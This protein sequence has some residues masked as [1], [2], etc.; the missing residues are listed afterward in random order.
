MDLTTNP[1]ASVVT[2]ADSVAKL[3]ADLDRLRDRIDRYEFEAMVAR[4]MDGFKGQHG[5]AQLELV[6]HAKRTKRGRQRA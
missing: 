5:T 3:R 1:D 6:L 2:E 4:S